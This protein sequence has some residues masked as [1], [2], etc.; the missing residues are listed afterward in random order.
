L[1]VL[2]VKLAGD[3]SREALFFRE[4]E[5]AYSKRGPIP[6]RCYMERGCAAELFRALMGCFR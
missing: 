1:P 2:E 4:P 5:R 6:E 3:V